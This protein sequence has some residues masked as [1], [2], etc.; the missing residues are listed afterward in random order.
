M[1]IDSNFASLSVYKFHFQHVGDERRYVFRCLS[2]KTSFLQFNYMYTL[3]SF[4]TN[5]RNCSAA[6]LL[7]QVIAKLAYNESVLSKASTTR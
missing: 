6:S 1:S 3:I 2:R 7:R 4:R 5:R